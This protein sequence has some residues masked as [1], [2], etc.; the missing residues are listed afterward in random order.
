METLFGYARTKTSFPAECAFF[1]TERNAY[2]QKLSTSALLSVEDIQHLQSP[3]LLTQLTLVVFL[4]VDY[5]IEKN[6]VNRIIY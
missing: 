5:E 6:G 3:S 4:I 2:K 1:E